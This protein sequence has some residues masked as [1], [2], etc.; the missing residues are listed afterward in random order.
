MRVVTG[1]YAPFLG[2]LLAALVCFYGLLVSVTM[3][4]RGDRGPLRSP[5]LVLLMVL[6]GV[7]VLSDLGHRA[8]AHLTRN[9]VAVALVLFLAHF[10]L[11]VLRVPPQEGIVLLRSYLP[12]MAQG[13]LIGFVA[14]SGV[15]LRV[16]VPGRRWVSSAAGAALVA[17]IGFWGLITF[18]LRSTR[19]FIRT[20]VLRL[21]LHD[22]GYYQ[23]LA[24]Y[25]AIA[26][27]IVV[28]LQLVWYES[29]EKDGRRFIAF[30]GLMVVQGVVSF[31]VLQ[32]FGSN[33][34]PVLVALICASGIA[35]AK[36]PQ[37][38]F[39]SSRLR[40]RGFASMVVLAAL[41]LGSVSA[42]GSLNLPAMRILD[43]GRA[44]GVFGSS[45]VTARTR[46]W[47]EEGVSQLAQNPLLGDP[48]I[49]LLDGAY[50]HSIVSVQTH[51]GIIGTSL[52]LF[53]LSVGFF[54]LRQ[55][56]GAGPIRVA[57]VPILSV[58]AVSSFFVWLPLW[59]AIGGLA[60]LPYCG[61]VGDQARSASGGQ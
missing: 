22:A 46:L 24:D 14:G 52:L 43:Y 10:L 11:G 7:T 17:T 9:V 61:D 20:D 36:P 51:L 21:T 34:G 57:V 49:G 37:W 47:V 5:E 44:Q 6:L 16:A 50:A 12:M 38:V 23:I 60:A 58:G 40:I 1:T 26:A 48:G 8:V 19:A 3:A 18:M 31:L 55:H 28:G 15:R 53:V 59:F 33:K 56:R 39:R 25:Y 42:I 45:S 4:V 32:L 54:R 2:G 30:A 41:L 35:A 29:L 13:F 27:A